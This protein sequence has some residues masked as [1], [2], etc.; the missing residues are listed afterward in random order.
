MGKAV[1]YIIGV[2]RTEDP[3]PEIP[4]IQSRELE[5]LRSRVETLE[6]LLAAKEKIIQLQDELLA[7][8]DDRPV[9]S[10]KGAPARIGGSA[11]RL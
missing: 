3:Q 8:K 10:P 4:A 1:T 7:R 9:E 11:A 5:E 6:N 2:V